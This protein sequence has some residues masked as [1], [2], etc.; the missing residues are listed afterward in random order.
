MI[1][2][3]VLVE[4]QTEETFVKSVLQPYFNQHETYLYPRLLG[5]PG[6]KGGI[7]EYARARQDIL[8]MLKQDAGVFCT[9]MF[10][11]YGM[12]NSWPNRETARQRPFAER[13]GVI[14]QAI[15]VDI[16]AVLGGSFNCA[17]LIPYVQ[18]HEFE[19]LLFSDPKLLADG[20]ALADD[21]AV[22]GIRD[23]FDSP[24]EIN[25]SHQA[26]PSKRILGLKPG[27]AKVLDGVR[28]SQKIGLTT[29]RTQCPHF[30]EWIG[31]LEALAG[32]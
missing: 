1:R 30:N 25:D 5:K 8:I 12:P 10:D 29:M 14:E 20:L 9:T 27:Y 3:H 23:H 6:H 11:Y 16:S 15:L 7:G 32:R 19:A 2:V 24:E 13:P 28:I 17:R 18:M 21:A 26:A 31:K 22:R 4:G